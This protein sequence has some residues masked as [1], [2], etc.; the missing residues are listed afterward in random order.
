MSGFDELIH[1]PT[2]LAM[3]AMLSAVEGSSKEEIRDGVGMSDSALSKQLAVLESAGY[4]E[5]RKGFVGKRPRTTARLTPEGRAAFGG[6][7]A[8]LREIL[9]RSG[10]PLT[11]AGPG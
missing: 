3:V 9:A 4:V 11:P 5:I 10:V 1:S 6:H 7:V 8:A 2:R